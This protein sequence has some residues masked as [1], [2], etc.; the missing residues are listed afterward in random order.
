MASQMSVNPIL[1]EKAAKQ[2]K[3]AIKKGIK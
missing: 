1:P 2:I 3:N